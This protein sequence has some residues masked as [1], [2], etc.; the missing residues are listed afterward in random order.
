K[1]AD[2]RQRAGAQICNKDPGPATVGGQSTTTVTATGR[3][4]YFL[5]QGCLP[6][7]IYSP[8]A[9]GTLNTNGSLGGLFSNLLGL[10]DGDY[11]AGQSASSDL[12]TTNSYYL[13]VYKATADIAMLNLELKIS[14]AFTFTSLTSYNEDSVNSQQD[15]NR[16]VPN[17][18]FNTTFF[19][20]GGVFSDPQ[21]GD[22]NTIAVYDKSFVK[23]STWTQELRLQSSL[24][25]PI[26]F[27]AGGIYI[28]QEAPDQ[29]YY[30]FFNT[31][32]A[33]SQC[34]NLGPCNTPPGP[35]ATPIYIDP[36][37][38]PNGEGHN[39]YYNKQTFALQSVAGFGEV[40]W[41]II[42]PLKATLGLRYTR[43]K[44]EATTYDFNQQFIYP[45]RGFG[46]SAIKDQEA[47]FKETTGRAGLDWKLN[48]DILLYAFYSKGYKGGGFNPAT[49]GNVKTTFDPEI[50]NAIELGAKTTF[51]DGRLQ[52]NATVFSYDYE[53][54]QISR[55]VNLTAVNDNIDADIQGAEFEVAFQPFEGTR[56]D[57][58][59]G[60]LKTEIDAP[61]ADQRTVDVMNRTQ[62]DPTRT[63]VKGPNGTNCTVPTAALVNILSAIN[64]N[65]ALPVIGV[66]NSNTLLGMCTGQLAGFGL[67][68]TEGTAVSLD[69]NELPN[70]PHWTFSIGAQQT[71]NFGADWSTTI[72]ADYYMQTDSYARFYNSEFDRIKGWDNVN[73]SWTLDNSDIGVSFM[74][75]VKNLLDDDNIVDTY[76]TDDSSGLYLNTFMSDPRLIGGS[77]T[78]RF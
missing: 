29:G 7:S 17:G 47:T 5:S 3:A 33:Y 28:D 51:A 72:R 69:G 70:S 31:G 78:W 40:Y 23:S 16:S 50:V 11:F 24:D 52:L 6:G 57:A 74:L 1:E 32:T 22:V 48:D 2:D 53:G 36:N 12:R 75:Y 63:L 73:L 62:G 30:V 56:L 37:R 27:N 34:V 49:A 13:P 19:T 42:D 55:I 76:L 68:P 54:Y 35:P 38:D 67:T 64:N 21:I 8:A 43:D 41:Q 25:G 61:R 58:N 45:G 10:Y 9:H 59:V 39:Y 65:T 20:P 60:Y 26:N 71:F 4:I 14:D 77:V 46:P 15:Y 18:K 66:P 44:K